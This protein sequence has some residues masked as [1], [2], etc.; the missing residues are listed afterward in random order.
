MW[1]REEGGVEGESEVRVWE[2]VSPEEKKTSLE[3]N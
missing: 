1:D 3:Q 2:K